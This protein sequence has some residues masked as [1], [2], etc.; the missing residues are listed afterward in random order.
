MDIG[1]ALKKVNLKD[2]VFW[3]H[4]SW[5]EV[6]E[7]CVK[8]SWKEIGVIDDD[9]FVDEDDLPLARLV[10]LSDCESSDIPEEIEEERLC[11]KRLSDRE[12]V[13]M[14]LGD[15]TDED[16]EDEDDESDDIVD[17][18]VLITSS[19]ETNPADNNPCFENNNSP[20]SHRKTIESLNNALEWAEVNSIDL[21]FIF[22]LRKVRE[23]AMEKIIMDK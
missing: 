23:I 9:C 16:G 1:A 13:R 2:V 17:D 8:R 14:V 6:G 7:T 19:I 3:L 18:P 10:G 20:V 5:Q 4:E 12:I 22:A 15:E 21:A 11:N